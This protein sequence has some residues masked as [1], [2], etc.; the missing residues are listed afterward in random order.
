MDIQTV[1]TGT[2]CFKESE[3]VSDINY[4]FNNK[5]LM[6]KQRVRDN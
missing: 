2:L 1:Y 5:S 3:I 4:H 6:G